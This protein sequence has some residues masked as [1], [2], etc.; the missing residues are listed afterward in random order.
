MISYP[1]LESQKKIAG[2]VAGHDGSVRCFVC[3]GTF[4]NQQYSYCE[5]CLCVIHWACGDKESGAC[6]ACARGD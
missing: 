5:A 3:L 6:K 1:I 2:L 4:H